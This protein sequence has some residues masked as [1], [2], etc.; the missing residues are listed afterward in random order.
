MTTG[1]RGAALAEDVP[2][3]V[4]YIDAAEQTERI[5]AAIEHRAYEI[6]RHRGRGTGHQLDD[7]QLA[8]AEVT[9]KLDFGT[10]T[11]DHTILVGLD[12]ADFESG[13]IEL[14]IAPHRVVVCGKPQG[15]LGQPADARGSSEPSMIFREVPLTADFEPHGVKAKMRGRFMEIRLPQSESV[16]AAAALGVA[17]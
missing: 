11:R 9:G 17:A 14:W 6:F 15:Y 5:H 4:T 2:V 1:Q 13:S 12:V 3:K 10:T 7:W 16:E 8:E